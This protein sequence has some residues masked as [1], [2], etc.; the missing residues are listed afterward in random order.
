MYTTIHIIKEKMNS[1]L[2]IPFILHLAFTLP[3]DFNRIK[4]SNNNNS[5]NINNNDIYDSCRYMTVGGC[6]HDFNSVIDVFDIP[7]DDGNGVALC[8]QVCQIYQDTSSCEFFNYDTKLEQCTL[9]HYRYLWSCQLLGGPA[10]PPIEDCIQEAETDCNSFVK[11]D[12]SFLGREVF[13]NSSV[14][15]ANYCQMMLVAFGSNFGGEYFLYEAGGKVCKFFDRKNMSC[16]GLSGPA[17]PNYEDCNQ[18]R[19]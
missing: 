11:E 14:T 9:F 17:Q 8:Q 18:H 7:N 10:F 15:D 16:K 12:C 1:I 5:S 4:N 2:T 13:S 19:P 6:N 3:S